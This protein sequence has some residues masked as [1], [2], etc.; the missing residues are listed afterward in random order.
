MEPHDQQTAEKLVQ[1]HRVSLGSP[2][3]RLDI[4][5]RLYWEVFGDIS[6]IEVVEDPDDPSSPRQPFAG[7]PI[8]HEP[9]TY[10]ARSGIFITSDQLLLV[11]DL[12]LDDEERYEAP[13]KRITREDGKPVTIEDLTQAYSLQCQH[14]PHYPAMFTIKPSILFALGV[15]I[16][17]AATPKVGDVVCRYTALT[18]TVVNYYTCSELAI[19]YHITV[20]GFFK[21]N[22]QV[23]LDCETIKPNTEYCTFST[24]YLQ[25]GSVV[26]RTAT[27]HVLGPTRSAAMR[28]HGSAGIQKKTAPQ[29]PAG[30]VNV[31]VS[32]PSTPWTANADRSPT[33]SCVAANGEIAAARVGAVEPHR[34]KSPGRQ[35]T[36]LTG[37][38]AVPRDIHV[39]LSMA[40]AAVQMESV[41]SWLNIA[42]KA[43]TTANPSS[44]AAASPVRPHRQGLVLYLS[45]QMSPKTEHAVASTNTSVPAPA[46]GTTVAPVDG[47]GA[48]QSTAALAARQNSVIAP[49]ILTF[50]QMALAVALKATNVVDRASVA[51]VVHPDTVEATLITALRGVKKHSQT[52]VSLQMYHLS[53][54]P[55]ARQRAITRVLEV[56]SVECAAQVRGSVALVKTIVAVTANKDMGN[57]HKI[58]VAHSREL[59]MPSRLK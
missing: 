32:R 52:R 18:P 7:H 54:V 21:L 28:K 30:P 2:A 50:L 3:C 56:P 11:G 33:V 16:A 20:E 4:F 13:E 41:V 34:P 57:V 26:F 15:S 48:R 12:S 47:V 5:A 1:G 19:R 29:V 58:D 8:A 43:D 6:K 9:V 27:L 55:A 53:T 25:T 40:T 35:A 42:G 36:R 51:V 38:A 45:L 22:P 24:L 59:T 10:D 39:A 49:A 31:S 44:E 46:L 17:Q 37:A 14:T 23:D